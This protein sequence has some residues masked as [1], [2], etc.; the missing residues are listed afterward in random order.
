MLICFWLRQTNHAQ[1]VVGSNPGIED[2]LA[3]KFERKVAL[4]GKNVFVTF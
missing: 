3:A 1:E 4:R 2:I